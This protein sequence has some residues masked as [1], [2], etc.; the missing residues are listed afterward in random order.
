MTQ[1]NTYLR[2]CQEPLRRPTVAL[3]LSLLAACSTVSFKVPADVQSTPDCEEGVRLEAAQI[4]KF[5][6]DADKACALL[7]IDAHKGDRYKIE[8]PPGQLWE[9]WTRPESSPAAGEA[10]SWFM[11]LFRLLRRM[12]EEPWMVLGMSTSTCVV[13]SAKGALC[14]STHTRVGST[15]TVLDVDEPVKISFFANDVPFLNWNN[16][17]SV[18]VTVTRV[19]K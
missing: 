8:V 3:M 16:R 1:L 11:N 17:G 14:T 6:V 18:W 2:R 9:D 15:S 7:N 19:E 5:R 10:G 13:H 4:C 12:P